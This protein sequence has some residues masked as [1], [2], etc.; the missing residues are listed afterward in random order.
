MTDIS[1]KNPKCPICGSI[2]LSSR[3]TGGVCFG[4]HFTQEMGT[5]PG[6]L[7]LRGDRLHIP[8]M[9]RLH[10]QLGKIKRGPPNMVIVVVSTSDD[11][12]NWDNY[13]YNLPYTLQLGELITVLPLQLSHDG[14]MY[15]IFTN[16]CP[17]NDPV[18]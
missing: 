3:Y 13:P 8:T 6:D 9:V 12:L 16:I 17:I 15:G 14:S 2:D 18:M 4:W 10:H 7:R 5:I 1:L 11:D